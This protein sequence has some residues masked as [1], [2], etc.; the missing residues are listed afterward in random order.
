MGRERSERNKERKGKRKR[1]KLQMRRLKR[2][3]CTQ[4]ATRYYGKIYI[5][6]STAEWRK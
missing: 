4:I 2:H 1:K 3:E 5:V 6:K